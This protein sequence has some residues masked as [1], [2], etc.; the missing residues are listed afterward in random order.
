MPPLTPADRPALHLIDHQEMAQLL[1]VSSDWLCRH[2]GA[3]IQDFG[4]PPPLAGFAQKRWDPQALRLWLDRQIPPHLQPVHL[5]PNPPDQVTGGPVTLTV[6][7]FM[8]QTKL[9]ARAEHLASQRPSKD[10]YY[11]RK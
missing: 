1:G 8:T 9:T 4:F 6:A 11:G 10:V 5:Q 7:D 3:L 2:Q